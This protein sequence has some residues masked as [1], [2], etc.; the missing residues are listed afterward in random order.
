VCHSGT[1]VM[2]TVMHISATAI[3]CSKITEKITENCITD[4]DF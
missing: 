1:L 4:T 2:M 3:S